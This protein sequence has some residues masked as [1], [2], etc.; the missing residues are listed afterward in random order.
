MAM[1]LAIAIGAVAI[2]VD[3]LAVVACVAL[4]AATLIFVF[5]IQP[6]PADS[7]P[8]RSHLDQLMERRDIVYDNLR[9]LKF[10]YRTGKFA[11][12][13]YEQMK[14]TLEAEAAVVLAEIE[15]VTG[16][17]AALPRSDAAVRGRA[18]PARPQGGELTMPRTLLPRAFACSCLLACLCACAAAAGTVTGVIHNGTSGAIAPGVDV[19]LIKLQGGMQPV[20]NTKSDAKG[21][22]KFDNP[23]IGQG[24]MLIRAVYHGVMFHQPLTPGHDNV[25]VTVFEPSSD[26]KIGQ[27]R[28]ARHRPPAQWQ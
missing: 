17:P 9:D 24:P 22:Y 8:H 18:V 4:T 26:S 13:D 27:R 7:A 21:A 25:D 28:L 2:E 11:E 20:A 15:R 6:D 12:E 19:I 23:A 1:N 16:N 10:E 14:Q 5:M 3:T